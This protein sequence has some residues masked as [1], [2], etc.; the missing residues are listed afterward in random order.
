MK[1]VGIIS[2]LNMD[3]VNYG[4]K[5]QAFALNNYLNNTFKC[6]AEAII[7]D[8]KLDA[9]KT[10]LKGLHKYTNKAIKIPK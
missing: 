10:T 6:E 9:K 3:N 4:N 5:L 1:K 8:N 7:I 2:E